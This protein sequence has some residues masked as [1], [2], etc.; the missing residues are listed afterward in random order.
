MD[1]KGLVS[2]VHRATLGTLGF[3]GRPIAVGGGTAAALHYGVPRLALAVG[4]N[5]IAVP[6]WVTVGGGAL[7]VAVVEGTLYY[8]GRTATADAATAASAARKAAQSFWASSDAQKEAAIEAAQK[9][10]MDRQTFMAQMRAMKDVTKAQ[11][12]D[13]V[14]EAA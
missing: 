3:A 8:W 11:E 2:S 5:P 4:G 14:R 7:A 6:V 9:Q 13:G 10:G 12:A 1:I